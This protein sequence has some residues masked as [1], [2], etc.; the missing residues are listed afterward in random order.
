M[1]R[2]LKAYKS[3]KIST[4]V[5]CGCGRAT[6]FFSVLVNVLRV[7]KPR[8]TM[9]ISPTS[10]RFPSSNTNFSFCIMNRSMVE[11]SVTC[12][13]TE[14]Q[15]ETITRSRVECVPTNRMLQVRQDTDRTG[16]K[17]LGMLIIGMRTAIRAARRSC[18]ACDTTRSATT[19]SSAVHTGR[20]WH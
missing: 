1:I 11:D 2:I 7:V 10:L 17:S 15:V 3:E 12:V 14:E 6:S 13:D 4:V 16:S 8:R 5:D 19:S 20:I 18:C 9:S